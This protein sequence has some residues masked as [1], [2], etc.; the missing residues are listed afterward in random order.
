L[1]VEIGKTYT[2]VVEVPFKLTMAALGVDAKEGERNAVIVEVDGNDFVLCTLS[3]NRIDQ[4]MLDHSFTEG[5]SISFSISG[6]S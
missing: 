5:T 3:G 4:Q 6:N 2:Q 1:T